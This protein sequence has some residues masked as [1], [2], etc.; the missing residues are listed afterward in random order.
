MKKV[1]VKNII[2]LNDS[3][4]LFIT[5]EKNDLTD[6]NFYIITVPTPVDKS[7]RPVLTPLIKASETVGGLIKKEIIL[8]M[9]HSLSWCN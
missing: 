8:F 6:C 7:K 9:V 1:C 2:Y 5:K 3:N 4:G